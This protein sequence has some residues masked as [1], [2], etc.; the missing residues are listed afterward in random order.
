[1]LKPILS[2]FI[3][4]RLVTEIAIAQTND[5]AIREVK[6]GLFIPWEMVEAPDGTI[7]FTQ[8]HGALSRLDPVSGQLKQLIFETQVVSQGEGGMLGL[9]L[10]PNFPATP[11]VYCVY[12]YNN[13]SGNYRQKLVVYTYNIAA[14]TLIYKNTIVDNITSNSIHNGS[15]LL[16]A[17]NKLFVSIG[18]AANQ[19]L[20]QN[21]TSLN[22]K[23]LRYNLDGSIPG[24][25][26]ISGS[27]VWSWG[28]RNPQGF[29][30]MGNKM[31]SSEHGPN[32]DD[33]INIIESGRNYGW[34]TVQGYCNTPAEMV[35][36]NDSNVYEPAIAWTPTLAVCGIA[37]NT[38]PLFPQWQN[39]LLMTTLKD[40]TLYI[41]G[42]NTSQDSVVAVDTVTDLKYG[43]LRDVLVTT[44]GKIYISTSN[45]GSVSNKLDK[46]LEIYD[47]T[48]TGFQETSA[49]GRQWQ[50]TPIPATTTL[51]IEGNHPTAAILELIDM[52]GR[53]AASQK[54][55]GSRHVLDISALPGGVYLLRI[56][57]EGRQPILLKVQKQ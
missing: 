37:F 32:N 42:F 35:F 49:A 26:P 11:D 33:E 36:C 1:M 20:P 50:V 34:P 29:T 53:V 8:R 25:N 12:N 5:Y 9:D 30:M 27:P 16:I 15:R 52:N 54:V 23:I 28:H 48:P 38:H 45:S 13:S 40:Q 4:F 55:S 47:P 19:A 44:N 39:K 2:F 21:I 46:I 57:E 7:W 43:R 56:R 14:D 31:V 18:D 24:D 3:I 22:G 6:G 10:H 41:L 17:N 51:V